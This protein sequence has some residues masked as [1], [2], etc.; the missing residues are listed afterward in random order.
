MQL[1]E[2]SKIDRLTLGVVERLTREHPEH[3]TFKAFPVH[4]WLIHHPSDF[5]DG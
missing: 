3:D 2:L 1:E 4:A 5:S